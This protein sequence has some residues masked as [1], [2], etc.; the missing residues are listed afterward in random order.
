MS[1]GEME[2][3]KTVEEKEDRRSHN[4]IICN[5]FQ[6][7]MFITVCMS[8]FCQ[9][10]RHYRLSCQYDSVMVHPVVG[11]YLHYYEK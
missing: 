2:R 5:N 3:E 4:Q 6:S 1:D 8:H 7:S 11:H 10:L 9:L